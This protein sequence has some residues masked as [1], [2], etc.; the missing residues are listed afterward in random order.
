MKRF[1]VFLSLSIIILD[2]ISKW[3]VLNSPD[4]YQSGLIELK[5]FKNS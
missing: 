5:L 4:L 3:L 2:R 1:L